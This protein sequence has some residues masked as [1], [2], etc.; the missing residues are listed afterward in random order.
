MN[1]MVGAITTT[2][3]TTTL[4]SLIPLFHRETSSSTPM[5]QKN[6]KGRTV[7]E[8]PPT[9]LRRIPSTTR[10]NIMIITTA[11][12]SCGIKTST[13]VDGTMEEETSSTNQT[14]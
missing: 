7:I 13:V 14:L 6:K 12:Q 11:M 8:R 3:K 1:M 4:T 2:T 10:G 9:S 5:I